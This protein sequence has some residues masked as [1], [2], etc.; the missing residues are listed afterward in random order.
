MT[1]TNTNDAR[2]IGETI[3]RAHEAAEKYQK[4]VVTTIDHPL[5]SDIKVP[6]ILDKDGF[7]VV[8]KSSLAEYL[9]HPERRTGTATLTRLDSF[10][11]HIVRF[12]DSDSVIFARDDRAS[13][14]LTAVLDYH[15][16]GSDADPRFGKHRSV[17]NFPLSDEWKVWQKFDKVQMDQKEFAEFIEDRVVDIEYVEDI[18]ALSEEMRRYIGSTNAGRIA[19]P[20]RMHEL[21]TNLEVYENSVIKQVQKLQ[22]GEAQIRFESEHVDAAGA[23]VDIPALFVICI[24]VF[25]HDGYYRIVARLRYRVTGGLKFWY[26]LWR[27]DLVF[28]DAFD[29]ACARVKAETELPLLVGAPE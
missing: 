9:D 4:A 17:F 24:P 2:D 14:A 6:V 21:S 5:D 7:T 28:D 16:A 20:A 25:A 13:P 3:R 29:K 26:E 23:P 10:I 12:K 18:D 15:R 11:E 22:T 27:T 19:T 8:S 1:A